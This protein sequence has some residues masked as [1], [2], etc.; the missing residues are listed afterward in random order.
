MNSKPINPRAAYHHGD[1]RRALL[2]AALGLVIEAGPAAFSLRDVARQVG[3]SHNA[4]YRHFADRAALLAAVAEE[5]FRL[6]G[7]AMAAEAD[8]RGPWPQERFLGLAVAYV[9]FAIGHPGHFRVMFGPE[10]ADKARYPD[11]MA[12]EAAAFDRCVQAIAD[13]QRAGAIRPGPSAVHGLAAWSLV[14]GLAGL[15]LDGLVGMAGLGD[16]SP[17]VVTERMAGTLFGGLAE[18]T[19]AGPGAGC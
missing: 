11:V 18:T 7:R 6:L 14:H 2:D 16:E 9:G 4:P 12:A 8:R 15:Y 3:C 10:A 17:D 1:L 5:G 13:C 19:K